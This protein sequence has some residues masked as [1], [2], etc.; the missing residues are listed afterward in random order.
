MSADCFINAMDERA[1][2]EA[3]EGDRDIWHKIAREEG[4][5]VEAARAQIAELKADYAKQQGILA[6]WQRDFWAMGAE[7][8]RL[9]EALQTVVNVGDRA[10]VAAARSVLGVPDER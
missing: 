4:E 1:R 8:A 6:Q 2:A 10:A 3:A 5:R 7:A 9:R